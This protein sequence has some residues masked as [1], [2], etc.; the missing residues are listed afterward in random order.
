MNAPG[1]RMSLRVL[2]DEPLAPALEI[3]GLSDDSRD[4]R[5]G[6][7]F[8]AVAGAAADGHEHAAVA[9]E[10]GA[11]CVL[12]ERPLPPLSAPVVQVP[13]LRK[14][15]GALAAKLHAAPSRNMVCVGVTGTNGK[16]SIAYQLAGLAAKLGRPAAYL[17]TLGWGELGALAPS[18]LTT[19]SAVRT[20]KRLACLH[21]RGCRWAAL[22]V[23]SHAL[24]QGRTD[25][26]AFAYAVFSNLSRDHL[27]YHGSLAAYG[28][29]KRRLFE[30]PSLRGA[31]INIGD[32]FGR[33]LAQSLPGLQ[34]LTYGGPSADL[35]W[36][37]VVHL[38]QGVRARLKSP[39]GSAELVA[40]VC[41]DFGLANLSA[42]IG[43]LALD[44]LPF[45]DI[46][47]AAA[48]APGVPGRME[49]FRQPGFP[50]V[51]VDYAH[52]P[53]ALAKVLE[54]LRRHCSGRLVCVVGC[55]GERDV[56][57]R[58]LMARAAVELADLVWL[59]SDN[60]RRE[61]PSKIIADMAAG[62]ADGA[63]AAQEVDRGAAIAA[64]IGGAGPEDLVLVAGKG[65]EDYQEVAGRRR[66]FSDRQLVR[67]TLGLPKEG[68]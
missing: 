38:R 53:D 3:S 42:A 33:R 15:R 65:H 11:A 29:A 21:R 54:A 47:A 9:V 64:A 8:V 51:V 19:E 13:E 45:A 58:P 49:F 60:P 1:P 37:Q 66:P 67:E 18:R 50:T 56:G 57:K 25:D 55:G 2:L 16:T 40:P 35:C 7:A 24:A 39:W 41:G 12:A 23:S 26:V 22:E 14:R 34:A 48:A 61:D 68:C 46:A 20:Q 28:A 30:F 44:G 31:V 59:T 63:A 36:E 27:D 43:T 10:R 52:S 5:P 17:G 32:D 6:D 62:L 4:V